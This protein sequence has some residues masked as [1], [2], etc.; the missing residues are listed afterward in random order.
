MTVKGQLKWYGSEKR[1]DDKLSE[2]FGSLNAQAFQSEF[3]LTILVKSSNLVQ[4]PEWK[5]GFEAKV[6]HSQIIPGG[7]TGLGMRP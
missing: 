3:C 2:V 7:I 6:A 1:K 4:N 5:H